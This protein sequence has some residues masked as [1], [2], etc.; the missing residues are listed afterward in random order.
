MI[1]R[2][3]DGVLVEVASGVNLKL[4]KF[5]YLAAA[6]PDYVRPLNDVL[7]WAIDIYT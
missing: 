1:G 4:D 5:E 6:V 3:I 2:L 7:Y